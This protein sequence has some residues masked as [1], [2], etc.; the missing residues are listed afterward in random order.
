MPLT[1]PH[2]TPYKI[3]LPHSKLPQSIFLKTHT[4]VSSLIRAYIKKYIATPYPFLS[5][6]VCSS[7]FRKLYF[8]WLIALVVNHFFLCIVVKEINNMLHVTF[9][10]KSYE[11]LGLRL[12]KQSNQENTQTQTHLDEIDLKKKSQNRVFRYYITVII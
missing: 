11:N 10:P 4:T 7:K 2:L 1:L 5:F 9:L 6:R 12:E 8:I 3:E